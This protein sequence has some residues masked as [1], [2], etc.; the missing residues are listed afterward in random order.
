M[1]VTGVCAS[2]YMHLQ[3]VPTLPSGHVHVS[4]I[5]GDTWFHILVGEDILRAHT[6]PTLAALGWL[7][8]PCQPEGCRYNFQSYMVRSKPAA[9]LGR[10][11]FMQE[12]LERG[13]STWRG[14]MAIH[15]A[16]GFTAR[17]AGGSGYPKP[18]PPM[19]QPFCRCFTR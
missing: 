3:E 4:I 9:S 7:T 14:V 16:S 11:A 12:L 13:V 1:L 10:D 6:W 15:R 8:P 2:V 5:E 17:P 19:R 18:P